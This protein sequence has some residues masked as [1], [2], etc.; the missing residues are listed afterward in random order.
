MLDVEL[1]CRRPRPM[2]ITRNIHIRQHTSSRSYAAPHIHGRSVM[3]H[4]QCLRQYPLFGC[5]MLSSLRLSISLGLSST[6][7][8]SVCSF[9]KGHRSSVIHRHDP[10]SL[11]YL[12]ALANC[13]A[14]AHQKIVTT[15]V[16]RSLRTTWQS[17][18]KDRIAGCLL[19][20]MDMRTYFI[21]VNENNFLLTLICRV[22]EEAH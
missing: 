7:F 16:S 14:Q 5:G 9:E 6:K 12:T 4:T 18:N 20:S 22:P 2:N 15:V 21:L 1:C 8:R 3:R 19:P 10:T 17:A 13:D 11:R